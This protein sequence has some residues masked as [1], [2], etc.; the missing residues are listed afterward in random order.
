[1]TLATFN[2]KSKLIFVFGFPFPGFF[3]FFISFI[4]K[5][6]MLTVSVCSSPF[7]GSWSAKSEQQHE[8]I[9]QFLCIMTY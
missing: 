2:M 8:N 4:Y 6:V 9:V 7:V 5:L 1:M 3:F